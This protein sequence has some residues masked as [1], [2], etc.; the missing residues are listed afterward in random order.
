[1]STDLLKQFKRAIKADGR[2]R[3]AIAKDSGLSEAALSRFVHN[4]RGLTVDS[5][6]LLA[7][8]LGLEIIIRPKAKRKKRN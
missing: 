5:L 6:E 7:D 1:M 3:Y 4:E 2:T 8:V